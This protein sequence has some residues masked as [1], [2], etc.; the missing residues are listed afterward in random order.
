VAGV[1]ASIIVGDLNGDGRNDVVV[2][3]GTGSK[4]VTV[5]LDDGAGGFAR[6][7]YPTGASPQG[8]VLADV[9]GDG[10]PDVVTANS[11]AGTVSVLRNRGDGTLG[12][13]NSCG[14]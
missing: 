8:V 13:K 10:R 6:A 3:N 11:S 12:P 4:L 9:N 7:D 14:K 5:L 2:A 1:P